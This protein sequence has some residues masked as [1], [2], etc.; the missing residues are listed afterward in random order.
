MKEYFIE[1]PLDYLLNV[2]FDNS[3]SRVIWECIQKANQ[4]GFDGKRVLSTRCY[5]PPHTDCFRCVFE[6]ED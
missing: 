1:I 2:G 3:H 4:L 6:T 5:R